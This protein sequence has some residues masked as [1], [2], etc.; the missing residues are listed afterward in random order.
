MDK[1][2]ISPRPICPHGVEWEIFTPCAFR[3]SSSS[4][5]S[6]NMRVNRIMHVLAF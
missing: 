1:A 5:S 6:S 2:V 4:S 3:S